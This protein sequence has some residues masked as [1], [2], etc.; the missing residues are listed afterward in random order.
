MDAIAMDG[1]LAARLEAAEL[2][3][4]MA[5]AAGLRDVAHGRVVSYSRKVF[6]PLTKLCRDVC[7][8]CTFAERPKKGVAA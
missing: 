5:E 2:S 3:A 6:I 7:H 1:V 8:Y 4:L